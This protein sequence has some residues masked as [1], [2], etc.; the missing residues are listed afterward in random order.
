MLQ[1]SAVPGATTYTVEI[2]CYQ[3][4]ATGK[5]CT[6]VGK[7]W[8]LVANL[9]ET[10]YTFDFVGA[11]PGRWRVWAVNAAG[12]ESPKTGWWEFSYTQ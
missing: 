3:C 8:K 7:T 2:D 6:D 9:R 4:C 5:W 12:L 11:Q 1:W 10:N